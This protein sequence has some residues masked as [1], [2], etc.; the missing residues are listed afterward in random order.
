YSR[1]EMDA[2]RRTYQGQDEINKAV[3]EDNARFKAAMAKIGNPEA[4]PITVLAQIFESQMTP[5]LIAAELGMS[6]AQYQT[7]LGRSRFLA[8]RL[9]QS[10][11]QGV[12]LKRE[13]FEDNFSF[14]VQQFGMGRASQIGRFNLT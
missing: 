8:R 14:I 10:T 4:E 3:A 5:Q 11:L 12:P 6:I 7:R 13:I 2:I 9:G 1:G